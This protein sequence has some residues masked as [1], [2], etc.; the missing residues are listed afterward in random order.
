MDKYSILETYCSYI[1]YIYSKANS[2]SISGNDSN[3]NEGS[4]KDLRKPT[5]KVYYIN[6]SDGY[7]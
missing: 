3:R 5:D 1:K 6:K 4:K 2:N 7:Y